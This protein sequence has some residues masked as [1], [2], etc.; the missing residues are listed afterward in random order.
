VD[1]GPT[2]DGFSITHNGDAVWV[3][4]S[5]PQPL[6]IGLETLKPG[7]SFTLKATWDGMPN[8]PTGVYVV[9]N[10]LCPTGPTTEFT[11]VD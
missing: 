8:E 11:V 4:N 7:Q 5:G 6:Y 9:H 1:F 3:S 2:I 10:E